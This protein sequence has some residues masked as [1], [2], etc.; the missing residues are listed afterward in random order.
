M[1]RRLSIAKDRIA[2]NRRSFSNACG[3]GARVGD[4]FAGA[5]RA[6]S[7][8]DSGSNPGSG[9]DGE[10]SGAGR[11]GSSISS[12]LLLWLGDSGCERKSSALATANRAIRASGMLAFHF[13]RLN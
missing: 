1:A 13:M 3:V 9:S 10:D 4:N 2:S 5:G 12:V 11:A 8:P 6:G 7:S